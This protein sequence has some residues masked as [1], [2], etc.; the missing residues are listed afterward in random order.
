[1]NTSKVEIG[2]DSTVRV[3]RTGTCKTVSGKSTLTYEIGATLDGDITVRVKANSGAG[4][5]S[6]EWIAL[7]AVRQILEKRPKG[8]TITSF[9]LQ[10]LFKGK[11]V[12]TPAFL[13][14]VLVQEK[15]L[16]PLANK[17]RHF[18]LTDHTEFMAKV[19]K[20]MA[21]PEK[22]KASAKS[23]AKKTS[24]KKAATA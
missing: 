7:K 15:L 21:T 11:S 20:L 6:P 8:T 24:T 13:A 1:M 12:N 22:P 18:E 5:F 2:A 17:Q 9:L 3:L 16:R 4:F 23:T 10:P 14:A 19:E